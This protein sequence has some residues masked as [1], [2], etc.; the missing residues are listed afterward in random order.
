MAVRT[1]RLRR[2]GPAEGLCPGGGGR[3]EI[4]S[5]REG[6][7]GW[8]RRDGHVAYRRPEESDRPRA[9]AAAQAVGKAA[10]GV[11]VRVDASSWA[12]VAAPS[13]SRPST[14]RH[15]SVGPVAPAEPSELLLVAVVRPTGDHHE[16]TSGAACGEGV[17]GASEGGVVRG[18]DAGQVLEDGLGVVVAGGEPRVGAGGGDQADEVLAAR[19]GHDEARGG[20]DR[21]LE[22]VDVV[23]GCSDVEDDRGPSLPRQLVLAHH[24][25]VVA[26][27]RGPVDPAEVVAHHVGTQRVEVLAAA[28]QGV[29]VLGSGEGVVAGGE[30][31]GGHPL[32]ERVDDQLGHTGGGH[33]QAGQ[34]QRVGDLHLERADGDDPAPLR[35]EAVRGA[36]GGPAVQRVDHEQRTAGARDPITQR[37]QR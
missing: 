4:G 10:V 13:S 5:R 15:Q 30:R 27:G 12:S 20:R 14:K 2:A 34:A 29:G 8:R 32:H 17:E 11:R 22:R 33:H 6:L 3:R 18:G 35:G 19:A 26:G 36:G 31:D 9:H 21:P 7:V 25:V 37:E 28:A 24:E 23:A 1:G 16:G